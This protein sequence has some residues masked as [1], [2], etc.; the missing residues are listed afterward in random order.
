MDVKCPDLDTLGALVDR[1][2]VDPGIRGHL[3]DCDGC[4]RT[5]RELS[6]LNALLKPADEAAMPPGLGARLLSIP[7][8][9]PLRR[10]MPGALPLT[11][12]AAVLVAVLLIPPALSLF[13]SSPHGAIPETGA[14]TAAAPKL[15]ERVLLALQSDPIGAGGLLADL[16]GARLV[17]LNRIATDEDPV[18]ARAALVCLAGAA[19]RASLPAALTAVKMPDR[20]REAIDLLAAL[21]DARALADLEPLLPDARFTHAVLAALVEIGGEEAAGILDRS[22]DEMTEPRL[23]EQVLAAIARVDGLEGARI[24]LRRVAVPGFREQALAAVEGE[25]DL[26]LPH[27]VTLAGER[28]PETRAAFELLSS[29]G[30]GEAVPG[31]LRLLERR[32]TRS[33]AALAL[34]RIDT[35]PAARALMQNARDPEVRAAFDQAGGTIES[36]L[37][38]RLE[39]EEREERQRVVRLLA[40]CGRSRA[41]DALLPLARDRALAP[42]ILLALGEIGGPEGV[43]ALE[44]LA[45]VPRLTRSALRALGATGSEDAIPVLVRLGLSDRSLRIE[46]VAALGQISSRDA[47]E[48]ILVLEPQRRTRSATARAL[49]SMDRG[50]VVPALSS[51]LAGDLAP[52]ARTALKT[53]GEAPAGSAVASARGPTHH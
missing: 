18:A 6:G 50:V 31:L 46:A 27:L 9:S 53:L 20:C 11:A 5:V 24:L 10:P 35:V 40:R 4:A 12:A 29:L 2:A 43:A 49:R 13:R 32:D 25:A 15:R 3:A 26:L 28:G 22:L 33:D 37:I 23:R 21:G 39:S 7:D 44:L 8:R 38:R 41:V 19:P 14:P 1:E 42:D 51:L 52:A 30:R 34:A 16:S 45:E 47:V 17:V 36:W 48:G